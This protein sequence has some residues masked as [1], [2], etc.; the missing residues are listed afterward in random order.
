ML[1][2]ARLLRKFRVYEYMHI[3]S[4]QLQR[5]PQMSYTRLHLR[6]RVHLVAL[7]GQPALAQSVRDDL[8][9]VDVG[10]AGELVVSAVSCR[11][12]CS[13]N[14]R[15][16][17]CQATPP[18]QWGLMALAL[19]RNDSLQAAL[20]TRVNGLEQGAEV[21]ERLAQAVDSAQPIVHLHAEMDLGLGRVG[22]R[23]SAV[24][25]VGA[26]VRCVHDSCDR[27]CLGGVQCGAGFPR[28][29]S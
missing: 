13:R 8:V 6:R 17:Q 4:N 12:P 21:G 27:R 20:V 29:D 26:R 24:L 9:H 10:L 5:A 15:S 25:D 19:S 7:D 11:F 3:L 16:A 22:R 28:S 18:W 2:E 1:Q 14:R 23:V